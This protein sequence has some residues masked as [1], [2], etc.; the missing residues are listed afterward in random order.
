MSLL[1]E[2][3]IDTEGLKRYLNGELGGWQNLPEESIDTEGLKPEQA[4]QVTTPG[5]P[6]SRG[7]H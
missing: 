4:E 7:I 1:P 3:S 2:E 5:T 6:S